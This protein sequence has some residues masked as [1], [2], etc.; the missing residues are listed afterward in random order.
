MSEQLLKHVDEGR[1]VVSLTPSCSL[2]LKLEW[3]LLLPNHEGVNRLAKNTVD[4]SEYV[5]GLGDA[6]SKEGLGPVEGIK[7]VQVTQKKKPR[8]LHPKPSEVLPIT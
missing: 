8:A 4:I 6:L 3:P 5:V 7:G 1:T 2:M